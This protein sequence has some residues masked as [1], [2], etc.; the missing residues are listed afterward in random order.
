MTGTAPPAFRKSMLRDLLLR[1]SLAVLLAGC[2][3][4]PQPLPAER[5]PSAAR[6]PSSCVGCHREMEEDPEMVMAP[7]VA[8]WGT[9]PHA[10]AG[11]GCDRCHGGDPREPTEEAM[12]GAR[13][14]VGVTPPE[15][16]PGL[17]GRCH[18]GPLA[19]VRRGS[20]P[21]MADHPDAGTNCAACH[22]AHTLELKF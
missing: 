6:K 5:P 9:G 2:G 12:R 8:E 10:K 22:D 4:E 1:G 20:H 16:V 21:G 11:V 19:E 13:G 18:A 14:F 17:C 3:V 15:F 7:A